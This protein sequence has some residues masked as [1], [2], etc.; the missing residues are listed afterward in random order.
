VSIAKR[1][2]WRKLLSKPA[3]TRSEIDLVAA[4]RP[5]GYASA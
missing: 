1:R 2:R 5:R 3:S 4:W